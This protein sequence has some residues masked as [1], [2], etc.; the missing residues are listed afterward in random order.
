MTPAELRRWRA[1]RLARNRRFQAIRSAQ[2]LAL[3]P[4]WETVDLMDPSG[5]RLLFD[6]FHRT[7]EYPTQGRE[8]T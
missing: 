1:E 2:W 7:S 6:T 8:G 4:G 3:N 5:K